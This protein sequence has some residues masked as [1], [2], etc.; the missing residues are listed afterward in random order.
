MIELAPV[1]A[2][3]PS[4]T[5]PEATPGPQM[6][7][8][9]PEE[10]QQPPPIPVLPAAPKPNAVVMPPQK[11]QPKPKKIVKEVPKPLVKP[12]RE[13]PAPRT[14]APPR[15]AAAASTAAAPVANTAAAAAAWRSSWAAALSFAK[16]YPE[17]ARARGEQGTVRLA[18]VIDRGGHVVSARLIG[19]SGSATLD[20]RRS[21]WRGMQAASPCQPKWAPASPSP[22]PSD[23]PSD[24]EPPG[25]RA[26]SRFF[27][28]AGHPA[29]PQVEDQLRKPPL[30]SWQTYANPYQLRVLT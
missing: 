25:T 16:H 26:R 24:R 2:A 13:P 19:S 14:S 8:A 9:Q 29:T 15:A 20:Q 28:R 10:V 17:A 30:S 3:P 6:R 12:A 7:E 23:T 4:E 21:T 18:L 27:W 22:S 1:D 5:P 11:P